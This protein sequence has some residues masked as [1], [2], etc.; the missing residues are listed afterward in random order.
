MM[1]LLK[2]CYQDFHFVV[3]RDTNDMSLKIKYVNLMV[4]LEEKITK[5]GFFLWGPWM[6]VQNFM[7]INLIVEIFQAD[8]QSDRNLNQFS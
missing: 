3:F 6:S 1:A 5:V 8:C 7:A 2:S 4:V